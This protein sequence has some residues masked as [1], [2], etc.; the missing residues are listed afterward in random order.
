MNI[1]SIFLGMAGLFLICGQAQAACRLLGNPYGA[2][3]VQF[4]INIGTVFGATTATVGS[5][6]A[7]YT[8]TAPSLSLQNANNYLACQLGDLETFKPSM[9]SGAAVSGFPNV[10][11]T[12]LAGIGYRLT[13]SDGVT[14]APAQWTNPYGQSGSTTSGGIIYFPPGQFKFELIKT[15]TTVGYGPLSTGEYGSD[16]VPGYQAM[17][18]YVTNG[19]NIQSGG[20]TVDADSVNKVVTLSSVAINKFAGVGSV[21]GNKAFNLNLSCTTAP[22]KLLIQFN[23]IADS[24]AYPGTLALASGST[25]AG[26]GIQMLHQN[27]TPV[28]LGQFELPVVTVVSPGT[29]FSMGFSG[30]YIQTQP[31]LKPGSANATATF[32]LQFN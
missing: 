31:S 30:Q 24:S 7:S 22:P 2:T 23:G 25:A 27:G 21:Q 8:L 10:Y 1:R 19:G 5:V 28:N 20:C 6:L 4:N 11:R 18:I 13:Y 29:R 12:N 32:T 14:F 3:K 15:A 16:N 26:I 17:Q 9:N